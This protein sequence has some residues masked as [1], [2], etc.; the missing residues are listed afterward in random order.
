MA[1]LVYLSLSGIAPAYL[2]VSWSPMKVV[3][4]CFLPHQGH[5]QDGPTATETGVLQLEVQNCGTAFQPIC[6]KL[7]LAFN[8]LNK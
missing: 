3:I 4:S 5:V 1:T 2:A 7:T 8:D 6:D